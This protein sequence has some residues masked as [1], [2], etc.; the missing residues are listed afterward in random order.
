MYRLARKG[1]IS[2]HNLNTSTA[3]EVMA[4]ELKFYG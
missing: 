4:G 1:L 3:L 2:M